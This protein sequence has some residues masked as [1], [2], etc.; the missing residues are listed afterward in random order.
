MMPSSSLNIFDFKHYYQ[1]LMTN[2]F[3]GQIHEYLEKY[4]FFISIKSW[5]NNQ[6]QGQDFFRDHEKFEIQNG[7]LCHDELLYVLNG[8]VQL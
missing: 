3:F 7:L 4:P 1:L 2:P 5:L 8:L 6:N